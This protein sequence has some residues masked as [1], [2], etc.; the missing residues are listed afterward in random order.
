MGKTKVLEMKSSSNVGRLY[1]WLGK[2]DSL[3]K[4]Y[5]NFG[6]AESRVASW[7]IKKLEGF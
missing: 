3:P 7:C 2:T 5:I 6:I 4:Y 1:L